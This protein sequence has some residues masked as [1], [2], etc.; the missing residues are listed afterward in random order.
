MSFQSVLCEILLL[1][2]ICSTTAKL[3]TGPSLSAMAWLPKHRQFCNVSLATGSLSNCFGLPNIYYMGVSGSVYNNRIYIPAQNLSSPN[4]PWYVLSIDIPEKYVEW[5]TAFNP[6]SYIPVMSSYSIA[7]ESVVV[8]AGNNGYTWLV[9]STSTRIWSTSGYG[10]QGTYDQSLQEYWGVTANSLFR[11]NILKKTE[12][13]INNQY[14]AVLV[15]ISSSRQ[16]LYCVAQA[17][18]ASLLYVYDTYLDQWSFVGCV[19]DT[20]PVQ[21]AASILDVTES[22]FT[23]M[24]VVDGKNSLV[25]VD[26]NDAS[27]L[28]SVSSPDP[29]IVLL[30]PF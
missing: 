8:V 12:S 3:S 20:V 23:F 13:Q 14:N 26:L 21:F 16:A 15:G 11:Q 30:Q 2:F 24:G 29:A 22:Y 1:C 6:S 27:V 19:T 28:Y 18:D 7:M 25:T 10:Q 5:A 4:T 9:N 17:A